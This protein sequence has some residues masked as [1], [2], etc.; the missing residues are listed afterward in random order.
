MKKSINVW[1]QLLGF[2]KND[3]DCGAERFFKQAGVVPDNICAL[4][5]HPDFVHLHQGMEKEYKL[6]P[7]N[8]AYRAIPRNTERARQDWT[9]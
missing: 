1:M 5:F 4:L 7:D 8:C 2:E 9:N 6:F 3:P